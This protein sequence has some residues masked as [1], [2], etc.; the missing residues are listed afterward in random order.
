M[1]RGRATGK[2]VVVAVIWGVFGG[3]S[4]GL[5]QDAEAPVDEASAEEAPTD[6]TDVT[7]EGVPTEAVEASEG[8]AEVEKA[9]EQ[10]EKETEEGLPAEFVIKFGDVHDWLRLTSGEWLKGKL[11][12][13]RE[14]E[15]E[16]DSDKLDLLTFSWD[17]VDQLHSPQINTY[18]FEHKVDVVGR[19]LVTKDKVL[20]ETAEGVERHA[21]SE[22]VTIIRG[23]LRERNFWSTRLSVGFSGSAG[24][25]N[26]GQMNAHWDL[27]RADQRT[28]TELRYDGTFGYANNE[29]TVNRHL[30]VAELKYFV[31]KRLFVVPATSGFLNDV[32]TNVKFRATP[33]AG[34]GVHVFDTKKV[35]W[36]LGGALGYQYTRFLSAAAGV[37]NPQNDG[38][39][40][41]RTYAD[42]DF[43]SD[44]ELIVEWR[45]N[46]VYTQIDLTNHFGR[47]QFSVEITDIFD[48]ETT[49]K[50]YRTENP[51]PRADGTIPKKND[52]EFIVSLAL[53]IG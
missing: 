47:A 32:F 3:Q 35:E 43:T 4:T 38:F 2:V 1:I 42:F 31:S 24:N 28:R 26:Q 25:T 30:G 45:S 20:I 21:R 15:I 53:E 40:S 19:G 36:D 29:Q 10:V 37:T 50:F 39:I 44:V 9:M 14:E 41:F 49:L 5:A 48:L 11:K 7:E 17:K 16:F 18:V 22:L 34:A 13:L 33:G 6:P 51:P 52:Y 27:R 8:V 12:R 23:E 46:V